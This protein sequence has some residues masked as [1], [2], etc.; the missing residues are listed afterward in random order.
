MK[1]YRKISECT[2][3]C[4]IHKEPIILIYQFFIHKN[5]ERYNEIKECLK[6]NVC[7]NNIS[8]IILANEKIY[9]DEELGVESDKIIQV[10]IKNRIVY[11][12]IFNL[13]DSMDLNGY[14]ITCNADIFFDNTLLNI[15]SSGIHSQKVIYAQLRFEYNS[16]DLSKCKLFGPTSGSQDTWI[17]HSKYN[18]KAKYRDKFNFNYGQLGCDNKIAYLFYLL[19]YNIKNEPFLIKTFHNHMTQIRNYKNADK[20]PGPYLCI[21]PYLKL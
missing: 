9:S 21:K 20:I 16:K 10:D 13:I 18:I 14:I 12:D 11:S 2:R 3:R 4:S 15:Y 8:K 6:F 5:K 7:N 17:F 19:G 1:V